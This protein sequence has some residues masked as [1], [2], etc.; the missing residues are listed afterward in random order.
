MARSRRRPA[1]KDTHSDNGHSTVTDTVLTIKVEG[2]HLDGQEIEMDPMLVRLAADDLVQKHQLEAVDGEWKATPEFVK[3]LS[4]RLI[5]M[6]YRC[7]PSIAIHAWVR[8][9]QYFAEIQKKTS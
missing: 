9:S 2:G 4:D 1:A 6:G 3:E 7:T 5:E 8:V